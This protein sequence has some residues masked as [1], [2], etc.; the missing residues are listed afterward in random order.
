MC[1]TTDINPKARV[2]LRGFNVKNTTL[3]KNR[4]RRAPKT[5]DVGKRKRKKWR[6]QGIGRSK[7]PPRVEGW[8]K[9]QR[10]IKNQTKKV[11]ASWT[12]RGGKKLHGKTIINSKTQ[13]KN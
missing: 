12:E 1:T 10:K 6:D 9:I 11:T 8:G 5:G 13:K 4:F 7:S 2:T 3:K